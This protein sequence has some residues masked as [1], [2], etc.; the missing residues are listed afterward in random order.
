MRKYLEKSQI[1][2]QLISNQNSK[3]SIKKQ[4]SL[5]GIARSS[6]YHKSKTKQ[7][8]TKEEEKAMKIID[9]TH[10]KHLSYGAR[11]HKHN[12]MRFG[13]N[14]SR[15]RVKKLMEHLRIKSC[16]PQP[17]TSIPNKK[18]KCAPYLL[19]GLPIRHPNQVWATDITYISLGKRH[20][21]LSAIIDWYSRYIVGWRLHETLESHEAVLCVES[22]INKHGIPAIINSDQGSTYTSNEFC[23]LLKDNN[24]RQSMDGAKRWADNIIIERWFRNLKYEQIYRSDYNT[25][26][27]LKDLIDEY[28]NSYNY[29]RVHS[30]LN[31]QTPSE[32]YFSGINCMVN[33]PSNTINKNTLEQKCY[34]LR[35]A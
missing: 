14:M 9:K 28:V 8:F 35:V 32:W 30:S 15:Y 26:D 4:C 23:K 29:D 10:L 13:I 17:K 20:V 1:I 33:N 6:F 3:L 5:L 19:R 11:S 2:K 34:N 12:L 24:I 7:L 31:Y 21:Y 16:A 27:D 18:A 25:I 22:A